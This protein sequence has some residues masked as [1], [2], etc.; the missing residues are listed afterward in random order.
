MNIP[1]GITIARIA[2]IPVFALLAYVGS[3]A[4]DTGAFFVFMV[5]SL[6]DLVDGYLARRHGVESRVGKFLDPLADKLLVG[7]ALV[8]LVD[9]RA[10]PL[11]AAVVIAIREVAVQILRIRIVRTGGDL[12]ASLSAKAKTLTQ[13]AMVG[14]WLL[15][16]DGRNAGHW[17][18]LALALATTL[19]SGAEYFARAARPQT[20]E[21]VDG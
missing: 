15:P 1:N 8:V 10:F 11:W 3:S 14:W 6:S 21:E 9:A 16:W 18:L 5:A 12:P 17:A 4:A 19:W 2:L 7:V 13:L 20:V